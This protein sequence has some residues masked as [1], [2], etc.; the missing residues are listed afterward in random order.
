MLKLSASFAACATAYSAFVLQESANVEAGNVSSNYSLCAALALLTGTLI[1]LALPAFRKAKIA[2]SVFRVVIF[3]VSVATAVAA[4]SIP[5]SGATDMLGIVTLIVTI[6]LLGILS[7]SSVLLAA[8]G[9]IVD[10]ISIKRD[11]TTKLTA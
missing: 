7:V 6:P 8:S 1:L 3:I 2:L 4:W 11:E 5:S 9:L 10:L